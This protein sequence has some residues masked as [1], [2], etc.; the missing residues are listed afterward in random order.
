MFITSSC[1]IRF[2]TQLKTRQVNSTRI[3]SVHKLAQTQLLWTLADHHAKQTYGVNIET[4]VLVNLSMDQD[5]DYMVYTVTKGDSEV[6]TTLKVGFAFSFVHSN[7]KESLTAS[8]TQH[9]SRALPQTITGNQI[10]WASWAILPNTDPC[11]QNSQPPHNTVHTLPFQ[12]QN[13]PLTQDKLTT[14]LKFANIKNGFSISGLLLYR[15]NYWRLNPSPSATPDLFPSP[16]SAKSMPTAAS[17]RRQTIL[18][19][20]VYKLSWRGV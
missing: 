17:P 10:L 15:I 14:N 8:L 12:Q 18:T 16:P 3:N 5:I 13:D 19:P 20:S 1:G 2:P 4:A 9:S 11:S 6:S 7:I